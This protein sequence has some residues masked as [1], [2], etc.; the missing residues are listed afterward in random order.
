[1]DQ[2]LRRVRGAATPLRLLLSA[3]L[4]VV[5]FWQLGGEVN[6]A[7]LLGW[8]TPAAMGWLAGSAALLVTSYALATLRWMQVTRA[9]GLRT[10]FD[11]LLAHS[12]A[13]QFVSNAL[14]TTIGGDVVRVARLSKYTGDSPASFSSVVLDRLTG[15]IVLPLLTLLGLALN[16][17]LR[18][19]GTQT[20]VV[21]GVAVGTLGLLMLMLYAADHRLLGG[22]FRSREGW[23]RFASAIHLGLGS[24]RRRP[25]AVLAVIAIGFVYQFALVLSAFMAAKALG[26]NVGL[27]ALMAFFPVVL[28]A[29]VM[30][31]SIAGLGVREFMFVFLLSAVGVADQQALALGLVVW[32]LTV[33]TSL[34]GVPAY[35]IGGGRPSELSREAV[36]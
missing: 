1:M 30:P 14:P 36:V 23:Q 21:V 22:R 7:T 20:R 2:V 34:L 3:S 28:I 13:G 6:P 17:S 5:I 9:L 24:L 18:E 31:I 33:A 15:W 12:M 26:I 10:R 32:I 4:L 16:P 19:L 27:T 11:S 25:L 29:Q 8:V 35:A